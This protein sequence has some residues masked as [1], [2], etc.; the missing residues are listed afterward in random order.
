VLIT[1]L[2][3]AA[4]ITHNSQQSLLD[5]KKQNDIANRP[6]S[7][8]LH[9]AYNAKYSKA[10][11]G[12]YDEKEEV[13]SVHSVLSGRSRDTAV[14][15]VTS[16][17]SESRTRRDGHVNAD[18]SRNAVLQ[19]KH[20][21]QVRSKKR[22]QTKERIVREVIDISLP[23]SAQ[24][25]LGTVVAV[26]HT[27]S[28]LV[29]LLKHLR[30][31]PR[32]LHEAVLSGNYGLVERKVS[33]ILKREELQASQNGGLSRFTKRLSL[34]G[35]KLCEITEIDGVDEWG[36]T[37]LVFACRTQRL[38]MV[39]LL[40]NAG[41]DLDLVEARSGNAP[42]MF[43]IMH[44]NTELTLTLLQ[45][46][47]SVE[48][49]NFKLTTPLM[50]ACATKS[51]SINL[52][53]TVCTQAHQPVNVNAQ[54]ENGWTPLHY[55]VYAG[56]ANFVSYLVEDMGARVGVRDHQ[57]YKPLHLAVFMRHGA[58]EQELIKYQ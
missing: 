18:G 5:A 54:D 58:C 34:S 2:S 40:I 46:G 33:Q 17:I 3:A 11:D 29:R 19:A 45:A 22:T 20:E 52:L 14:P 21:R 31:W 25:S 53:K 56:R 6:E 43:A 27:R 36:R 39:R 57:R 23:D 7:V 44:N 32:T 41:A 55:A 9:P 30:L 37:A 38:D 48:L 13:E 47:A 8:T 16:Y 1:P 4:L 12:G 50:M 15:S 26:K 24:F 42:L 49:C 28:P 10:S 35:D 51:R